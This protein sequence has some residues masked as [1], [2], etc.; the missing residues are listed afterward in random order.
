MK[1]GKQLSPE[2]WMRMRRL[3]G[4]IKGRQTEMALIVA[5]YLGPFV[6]PS[7][8]QR[9]EGDGIPVQD[10]EGNN[11]GCMD[12]VKGICYPIPASGVC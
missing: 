4:E 9:A 5:R 12:A 8:E 2:D 6:K 11:V 7:T 3:V 10:A 1:D